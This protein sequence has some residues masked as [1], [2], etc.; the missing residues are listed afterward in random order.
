MPRRQCRCLSLLQGPVALTEAQE[1][2]QC[3][4]QHKPDTKLTHLWQERM[5]FPPVTGEDTHFCQAEI[6][7]LSSVVYIPAS[8]SSGQA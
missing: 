2:P 3:M 7:R 1:S 5:F 8:L 6:I 4:V